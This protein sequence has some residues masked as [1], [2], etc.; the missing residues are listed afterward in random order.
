MR[1]AAAIAIAWIALLQ[2]AAAAEEWLRDLGHA[3]RVAE[4][5]GRPL[6]VVFRCVP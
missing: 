3:T 5:S 1:H 6:F 4:Q 2:P